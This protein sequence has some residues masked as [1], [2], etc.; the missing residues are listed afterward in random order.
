MTFNILFSNLAKKLGSLYEK[1]VVLRDTAGL[2]NICPVLPPSM[3]VAMCFGLLSRPGSLL[4]SATEDDLNAFAYILSALE[5]KKEK[6][7]NKMG[8]EKL[9]LLPE[10]HSRIA[11]LKNLQYIDEDDTVTMKGRC[12]CFVS[13]LIERMLMK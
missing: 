11:V 12:C 1:Y 7:T 6:L 5:S 2:K 8:E 9:S 13:Q 3:W 4:P 10:L